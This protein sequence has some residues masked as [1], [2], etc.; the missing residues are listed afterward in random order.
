MTKLYP[1]RDHPQHVVLAKPADPELADLVFGELQWQI[2][3]TLWAPAWKAIASE[4]WGG[5]HASVSRRKDGRL[6]ARIATSWDTPGDARE[7]AK[8]YV[9]SLRARFP[10]AT[11]DAQK[12]GLARPAGTGKVFMRVTG[13]R[14]F[15]VD[16]ADEAKELDAVA[17]TTTFK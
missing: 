3:F 14:V 5:D 1:Q 13:Q 2:Y 15:I 11:G 12:Q 4:G 17:K 16:G 6:I 9:E 10:S 8:A 7:F